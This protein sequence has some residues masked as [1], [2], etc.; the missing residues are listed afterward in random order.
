[1]VRLRVRLE[2]GP[3]QAFHAPPDVGGDLY[4]YLRQQL[5]LPEEAA[6]GMQVSHAALQCCCC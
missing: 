1:M 5:S 6:E 3:T 4:R 2:D